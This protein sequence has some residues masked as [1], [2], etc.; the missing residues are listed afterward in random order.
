MSAAAGHC[1]Q[2]HLPRCMQVAATVASSSLLEAAAAAQKAQHQLAGLEFSMAA[3]AEAQQEVS[4][5]Q[6][7]SELPIMP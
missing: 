3:F 7:V 5:L 1:R 6:Q 2:V 4:L